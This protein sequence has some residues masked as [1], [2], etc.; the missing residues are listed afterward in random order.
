MVEHG[1]RKLVFSSSC[2]VYGQ[3]ET[4]PVTEDAPTGAEAPTAGPIMSE[5]IL[6]DVAAAADL[7][8]V[9][10]R[11]FN[12]VGAHESGTLGE[13]PNG[14]PNNLVPYVMQVA[15][16]RLDKVG[17]SGAITTRPTGPVCVTTS[18]SST[19][20]KATSPRST[21]STGR[22]K[23]HA[24]RSTSAPAWARPFSR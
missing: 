1:V 8:V 6:R 19:S 11:Y 18:T 16:G 3:P 23:V 17:V 13:D 9:L 7:D 20:P 14:I 10:L 12:P 15:V 2:T 5:Q 21:R 22:C 24:R 4:I